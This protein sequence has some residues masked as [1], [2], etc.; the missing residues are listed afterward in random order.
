MRPDLLY[1][2]TLS[3]EGVGIF[4]KIFARGQTWIDP[5]SI[6]W[7]KADSQEKTSNASSNQILLSSI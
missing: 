4:H 1:F 2:Y 6:K 3:F 5:S 7:E